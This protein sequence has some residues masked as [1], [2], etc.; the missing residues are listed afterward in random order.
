[1]K[2]NQVYSILNDINSQLF[3]DSV[4]ATHDLSGIISMGTNVI[5]NAVSTDKFLNLLV[6]RIGKTVIRRL[7]AQLDFPSLYMNEFQFGAVL[8]KYNVQ[9]IQAVSSN[10][11]EIGAVGFTPSFADIHKPSVSVKYFDGLDTASFIVTIPFHQMESAFT[12]ESAMAAFFDAIVAAL[13][14]SLVVSINN[15]SRTA[16][17]N[18]IAEKL[19][20]NNGIINLLTEYNAT[21]TPTLTQAEAIVSPNFLRFAAAKIRQYMKYMAQPSVLYNADGNLRATARDNMHVLFNTEFAVNTQVWLESDTYWKS[22]VEYGEDGTVGGYT[23]VAFWQGDH[24][25][26]G[27]N[28]F[29]TNSAID[30][31]PSSEEGQVT[32][33]AIQQDGIIAVLADRQAIAVGINKRRSGTW[34]N[35]IDMY[36][37]IKEEFDTQYINDLGENGLIFLCA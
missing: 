23:E 29:A 27:D 7:D 12:S 15:M 17:N 31:I 34:T 18:F 20:A 33:S 14:D 25:A 35:P 13:N 32:P 1:M 21:F 16:V 5:G 26:T 9:P 22:L 37:N 36:T 11:W 28:A 3:G 30:V 2:V 19:K 10:N 24:T 6:D 8:A 4:L